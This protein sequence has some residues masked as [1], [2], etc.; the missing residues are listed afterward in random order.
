VDKIV[1]HL[2]YKIF[3]QMQHRKSV[4]KDPE[5]VEIVLLLQ[6]FGLNV[7]ALVTVAIGECNRLR[8]SCNTKPLYYNTFDTF[9]THGECCN[10]SNCNHYGCGNSINCNE[11][12]VASDTYCDTLVV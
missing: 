11:L 9:A 4:V 3:G 8:F 7:V 6:F 1:Q 12:G 2:H 5:M 10:K